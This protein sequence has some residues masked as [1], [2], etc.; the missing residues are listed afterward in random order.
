[1][2]LKRF[3]SVD[4][5]ICRDKSNE[6]PLL[7][8]IAWSSHQIRDSIRR[9]LWIWGNIKTPPIPIELY[10][11]LLTIIPLIIRQLIKFYTKKQP[12]Q[13]QNTTEIT[14]NEV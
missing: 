5:I 6:L 7:L 14:L 2:I 3:S 1:M 4:L 9:G 10:G 8:I 13:T 11:G 12:V